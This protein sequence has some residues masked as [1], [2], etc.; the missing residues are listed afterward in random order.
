M[1]C[2]KFVVIMKHL[3][4]NKR[5]AVGIWLMVGVAMII[6][7]VFLGS[8]R[9]TGSG[10]SITE[11]K[12]IMGALPPLNSKDWNEAFD[13][14][15]QIAQ[16]KYLNAHFTLEDFK[17]IFFWE[18]FHRLWARLIGI[19]FIAGFVFFIA[20]KYFDKEMVLP[21]IIL[22]GLG[23]LQGLVGWIMVMSGLNDT[24]LYVN[25]F[26][27]A[28]HFTLALILLCYTLWFALK[29]LVPLNQRL[30]NTSLQR[31]TRIILIVLFVQIVYGAF[32]SGLKAA[33]LAPT[34][35]SIN[36]FWIPEG[37]MQNSWVSHP[38]NVQFIH[39]QLAYLLA[40]L[41]IFWF[42]RARYFA[43]KTST[44]LFSKV[45]WW[46]IC[47]V[48]LQISLGVFTLLNAHT[49]ATHRFGVYEFFAEC[50]QL[51]AIFLLISLVMNFY[52]LS[53]QKQG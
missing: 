25:H 46:P 45:Y 30:I 29:L 6:V 50:H 41:I 1:T 12:P 42:V 21:F 10:L 37:L 27:L 24:N 47:L 20:K 23:A 34:W 36:G 5:K 16:F 31:F 22:F 33:P 28:I 39:R 44:G 52:I 32:M 18:W 9:L 15:K 43:N 13:G 51:V 26:K 35:P 7:E 2:L 8:T 14:Y 4:P 38:I 3:E 11:W 53:P 40:T 17:F 48:M 49:M 19:V